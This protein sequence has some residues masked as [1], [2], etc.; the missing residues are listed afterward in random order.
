MCDDI[1][2][3]TADLAAKGVEFTGPVRDQGWGLVTGMQVPG[4]GEMGL[5][6]PRHPTAIKASV[7]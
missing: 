2:A 1:E 5:Y 3:T 6:E 7:H 4:A